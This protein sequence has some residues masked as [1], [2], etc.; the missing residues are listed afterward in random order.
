[1]RDL[2]VTLIVMGS[3]PIIFTRPHVGILMWAWIGYMNPHRMSY[4]FA[5][6]FPFAA[7]VG[8]VTLIA[9]FTASKERRPM[10]M[11]P[12]TVMMLIW[13]L[14]M[15]VTT[16][17]GLDS[18]VMWGYKKVMKIQLM[19]F[20]TMM[21]VWG[22]DKII[23]LVWVIVGSISFF[24][25]KGG[26]F[27]I[28]SAG[29][30]LVWGPPGTDIQGNNEL[31]V[32]LIACVPLMMFLRTQLNNKWLKMAMLGAVGLCAISVLGSFSRGAFLAILGMLFYMWLKLPRKFIG[33]I[34]LII[35]IP[36]AIT[37]MP[38]K[39]T[40]RMETI[41]SYEEDGSAM[42]RIN[43]W[44]YAYN[45][46]NNRIWGAGFGG[47]T[48]ELFLIYAPDPEDHHDAH[49]V[50]FEVLGEQGWIGLIIFMS[51][52]ALAWVYCMWIRKHAKDREDLK[53]ASDLA[54]MIQ[55]SMFGFGI[56]GAF[57]GLAYWDFIYH[58]MAIVVVT[59]D[60]M[61]RLFRE[62]AEKGVAGANG[63]QPAR[64]EPEP[65]AD[66]LPD[67]GQPTGPGFGP[68]S[69]PGFGP[70]PA[71]VMAREEKETMGVNSKVA[72]A[73]LP[74]K[75]A[76]A[77][78]AEEASDSQAA[79]AVSDASAP[80]QRQPDRPQLPPKKNAREPGPGPMVPSAPLSALPPRFRKS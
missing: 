66:P 65:G 72:G 43:A 27:T 17:F 6:S 78:T 55:V 5:F 20:V 18:D 47:F 38:E 67:T 48:P 50:Y 58:I 30:A 31:A 63:R 42:G 57:L 70:K 41:E 52:P 11:G 2:L 62:E 61:E 9:L 29:G 71:P 37:M 77:K 23:Q 51:L 16:V 60:H 21:L 79:E 26:I 80:A 28:A 45:L 69:G 49:S 24:G 74:P 40:Q 75:K 64:G 3:L 53:W 25:V 33:V 56:G 34:I 15:N 4:G 13:V 7:L 1:M 10:P 14:W 12:L 39:Y 36:T 8:M 73:A 35:A 32:A 76:K 54:A 22:K 59:R 44:W 68:G 46:A 19:N